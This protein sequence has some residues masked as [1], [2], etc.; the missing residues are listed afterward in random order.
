MK[1]AYTVNLM[2]N[3]FLKKKSLEFLILGLIQLDGMWLRE[4]LK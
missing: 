1:H 3:Q 2:H 4:S